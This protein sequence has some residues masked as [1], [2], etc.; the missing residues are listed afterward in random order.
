MTQREP[1]KIKL[2]FLF[3]KKNNKADMSVQ[4]CRTFEHFQQIGA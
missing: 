1:S 2:P 3:M 4:L